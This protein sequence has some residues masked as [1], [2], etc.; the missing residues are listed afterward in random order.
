MPGKPPKPDP[1]SVDPDG[2]PELLTDR[3]QWICWRY[4]FDDSRDEWTKVPV[5]PGGGFASTTDS[6]TWRSFSTALG[7]HGR[8][9]S[10]TDGL[11]FV[12]DENG[13]VAGVDLDDCRD[14][15][16][17]VFDDWANEVL[18]DVPTFGEVSP[19]GT[20]AHLYGL[21]FVPGDNRADIEG[22]E[23]HIEMYDSGRF[24][25]VTGARIDGQADQVNQVNDHIKTVHL[26]HIA[27]TDTD[28]QQAD[29]NNVSGS[30]DSDT[31]EQS[32]NESSGDGHDLSDEEV[33]ERAKDAENGGDFKRLWSG[34]TTG[35]ESHSEADLALVGHLAFWTG[36]DRHQMDRM[37]RQ[38][39]LYRDK[40]DDRRGSQTYGEHTLD[41]ALRGRTEFYEPGAAQ[42][43]GR[44]AEPEQSPSSDDSETDTGWSPTF[45][46]DDLAAVCHC[47]DPS[48]IAD[49]TDREKAAGVWKL[50]SEH[51]DVHIRV[52]KSDGTLWQC[53]DG[54][55][56]DDGERA[57]KYAARESV[58]A[59]NYGRNVFDE[60]KAQAKADPRAVFEF[61]SFG[62]D[63]GKVAVKNGLL[64]LRKAANRDPDAI[65]KLQPHHEA[66]ARLPVKYDANADSDQWYEFVGEVVENEKIQTI[67]EYVGYCLHREGFPY[68]KALL[69][70]G[71]G[72]NG[73]STFLTVVRELLGDDHTETKPL[74]DLS[75]EKHIADLMGS[76]AN[77][78]ADL[79]E[80]SLNAQAIEKFKKLTG[81]D[82]VTA[83][84]MYGDPFDFNSTAKHLYAANQ[85]PDVSSYVSD[86]DIAFWRRW[87][88][89]QFPRYFPESERDPDLED[90]L[91]TDETLSAVLNWA[92]DG[93]ARLNEN[94]E[95]S[96]AEDHDQTRRTWQSWGDSIDEFIAEHV[97][98]DPEAENRSTGNVFERFKKWC[99]QTDRDA[100]VSQQRFTDTLK[101]EDVGYASSCRLKNGAITNG[102]RY[103][104]LSDE[105]PESD[106]EDI[107][108]PGGSS[109][110]DDDDEDTKQVGL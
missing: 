1:V 14:P 87:I 66:L 82:N 42:D 2:L 70:V 76:L 39:G 21:G 49:L 110:D 62:V 27:E 106:R 58:G 20:G 109:D 37:F 33:I 95:F 9:G 17:G 46:K 22:A 100:D 101:Q 78:D 16:T 7:Y 8:R 43:S 57:V 59:M 54:V 90:E 91:T 13:T 51:N 99:H 71:S 25:T 96:H 45:S 83:R 18:K 5:E 3:D 102:Y 55:W 86:H 24:F 61:D 85:V 80:G 64:N 72:A 97:E 60:V 47:E 88:L 11:G 84:R 68:G 29:L 36:G 41:E 92:I 79:S 35:Y 73:K 77:I 4:K 74:H 65:Q 38:S 12:F 28:D 98:R 81:G 108:G 52:Q 31:L 30:S 69:L 26:R 34:S 44:P 63:A 103:L 105:I 23:G 75:E 40:W 53:D 10:N 107:S 89:V 67:Q 48:E 56:S 50:I 32:T 94:K 104:G 19:S 6:D 93:W 15:E